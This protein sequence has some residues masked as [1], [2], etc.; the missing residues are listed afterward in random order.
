[1]FALGLSVVP[2]RGG[3]DERHATRKVT[4][5][6][7]LVEDRDDFCVICNTNDA[8]ATDL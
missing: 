2:F 5:A 4:A 8:Q 6:A 3:L 1:M 7:R